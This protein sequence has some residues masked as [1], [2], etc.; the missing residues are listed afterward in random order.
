LTPKKYLLEYWKEKERKKMK[1]VKVSGS[2]IA[3][4]ENGKVVLCMQN[5]QIRYDVAKLRYV[6]NLLAKCS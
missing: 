4:V 6:Q 1:A 5:G 3:F 2:T